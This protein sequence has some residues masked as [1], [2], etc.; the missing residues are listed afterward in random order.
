MREERRLGK[1][2]KHRNTFSKPYKCAR[3]ILLHVIRFSLK[4]GNLRKFNK[5][6]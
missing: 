6:T 5:S 2:S 4:K 1:L 3:Q